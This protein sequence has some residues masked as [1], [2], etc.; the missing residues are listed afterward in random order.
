MFNP[1]MIG[2]N[3]DALRQRK[4][5]LLSGDD[6]QDVAEQCDYLDNKIYDLLNNRTVYAV[7]QH[8]PYEF[9]EIIALYSNEKAALA[10]QEHMINK[11]EY[12]VDIMRLES[13][14]SS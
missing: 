13:S 6:A 1:E 4:P 3:I 8:C 11:G 14:F 10:H 2:E 12:F 9:T 5:E 7:Y